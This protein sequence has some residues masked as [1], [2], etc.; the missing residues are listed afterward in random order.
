MYITCACTTLKRTGKTTAKSFYA[1]SFK[2]FYSSTIINIHRK[3]S[4]RYFEET[5]NVKFGASKAF[6]PEVLAG[7]AAADEIFST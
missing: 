2:H 4:N 5:R 7:A 6:P 1:T 3:V